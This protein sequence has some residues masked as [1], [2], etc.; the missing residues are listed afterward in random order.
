MVLDLLF[1][2]TARWRRMKFFQNFQENGTETLLICNEQCKAKQHNATWPH[3]K[4]HKFQEVPIKVRSN[5]GDEPKIEIF[6]LEFHPTARPPDSFFSTVKISLFSI[7]NSN[8]LYYYGIFKGWQCGTQEE[9]FFCYRIIG[10]LGVIIA[11]LWCLSLRSSTVPNWPFGTSHRV[12]SLTK[13]LTNFKES[14]QMTDFKSG[15]K[16]MLF[17]KQKGLD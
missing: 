13:I 4:T 11:Y 3:W 12:F 10:K 16:R 2:L 15:E 14:V 1:I 9:C 6:S 7:Q 8:C 5:G 17:V